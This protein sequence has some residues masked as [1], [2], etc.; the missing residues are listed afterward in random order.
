MTE[1]KFK[2]GDTVKVIE[3]GFYEGAI[4][5]IVG[6]TTGFMGKNKGVVDGYTVYDKVNNRTLGFYPDELELTRN[7]EI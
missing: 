6:A 1:F 4:F 7:K 3:K 5:T 2:Y